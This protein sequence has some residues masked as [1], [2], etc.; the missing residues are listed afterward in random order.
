MAL[1]VD[2]HRHQ[3]QFDPEA[4]GNAKLT[5]ETTIHEWRDACDLIGWKSLG[6]A[7]NKQFATNFNEEQWQEVLEPARMKTVRGV[8]EL[9]STEAK[10]WAVRR[11]RYFG[12]DCLEA[13]VFRTIKSL[14]AGEGATAKDI[15]PSTSLAPYLRENPD[16]FIFGLARIAPGVLP[17]VKIQTP[18]YDVAVTLFLTMVLLASVSGIAEAYWLAVPAALLAVAGWIALWYAA[19]FVRPASVRFG[20]LETFADLS[21]LIS[22]SIEANPRL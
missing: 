1:I 17:P 7:L 20:M 12:S 5:F 6:Q 10:E 9:V 15:K 19:N 4:D 21:R 8:C 22:K 2:S 11:A 18:A 13:G 16:L 14:L 3:S